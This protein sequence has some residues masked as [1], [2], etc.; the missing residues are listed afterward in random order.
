[1]L[2]ENIMHLSSFPFPE[3]LVREACPINKSEDRLMQQ[4][5]ATLL[6]I[7]MVSLIHL[8]LLNL[9]CNIIILIFQ[10]VCQILRLE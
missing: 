2:K 9:I 5:S 8:S 4:F 6:S 10:S 3:I 1:M 7:I